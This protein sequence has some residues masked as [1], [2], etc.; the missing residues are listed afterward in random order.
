MYPVH[1][2]LLDFIT[3]IIFREAYKSLS[4]SLRSL[5][6]PPNFQKVTVLPRHLIFVQRSC[7][8]MKQGAYKSVFIPQPTHTGT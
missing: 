6:Q 8:K 3:L 5:L 2:I 4:S 1:L 7:T